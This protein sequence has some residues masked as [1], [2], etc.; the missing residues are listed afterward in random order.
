MKKIW[1]ITFITNF[2]DKLDDALIRPEE[3]IVNMNLNIQKKSN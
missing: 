2:K 3:L 1:S